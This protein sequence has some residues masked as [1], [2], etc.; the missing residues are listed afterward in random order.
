[1]KT[2]LLFFNYFFIGSMGLVV[3]EEITNIRQQVSEFVLQI[4]MFYVQSASLFT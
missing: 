2:H 3:I 4:T 1:M